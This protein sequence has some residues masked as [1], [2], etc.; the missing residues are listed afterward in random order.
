[1]PNHLE[2]GYLSN[3]ALVMLEQVLQDIFLPLLTSTDF[4]VFKDENKDDDTGIRYAELKNELLVTLQRFKGH[5]SHTVQLVAS[6]TKLQIPEGLSQL[7]FLEPH[8]LASDTQ[9]VLK[10]EALADEWIKTVS[11]ALAMEQTKVPAGNVIHLIIFRVL[12]LKLSFGKI[13]HHRFQ[14]FMNSL[15][16]LLFTKSFKL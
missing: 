13:G 15:I 9:L 6:E 7:N 8:E 1:M 12:W 2:I 3:Q 4:S 10:L 5:V 16:C 14:L 11:G